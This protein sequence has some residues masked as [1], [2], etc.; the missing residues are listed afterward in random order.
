MRKV[1]LSAGLVAFI[2]KRTP[3]LKRHALGRRATELSANF[4]HEAE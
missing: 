3:P 4:K 2:A 1:F